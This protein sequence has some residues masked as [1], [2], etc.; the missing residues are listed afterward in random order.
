[1]AEHLLIRA[2]F[3][4]P[5]ERT[6][7]WMMRQ[8][9][10]YLP[11]Y[12]AVREKAD[13]LTM[14]KT[15]ELA[16]EVSLQPLELVGVDAVIFF[17]DI[18]TMLEPMGLEL[19]FGEGEGP[20]FPHPVRTAADVAR[21]RVVDPAE[22]LAFVGEALRL[23]RE[24]IAGRVPLLGFS[25]APYTLATY[26]VEGCTGKNFNHIKRWYYREP[27][28]L[29]PLLEK[30][31]DQVALYL[32]YQIASGAEAVQLFD[33]W[34]GALAPHDYR[35]IA[36][37]Y[38]RRVVEQLHRDGVPVIL[39]INGGGHLLEEMATLGVDVLSLDWRTDM[40]EARARFGATHALQG[41]LDPCALYGTEET[42]RR[43][44]ARILE[45]AGPVGHIFN[46]G[47]GIL[48]DV[49]VENARLFVR[50]VKE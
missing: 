38:T 15:P 27:E 13:F 5:V 49:P 25:G 28:T 48:P 6:P 44:V 31:A 1:M 36:A 22:G 26:A 24:R 32:N 16:A 45:A 42:I 34:A 40:A 43:E 14:C 35:E 10:R 7:V 30:L 20:R 17:S 29:R 11:E 9:G 39:Y 47:H 33:T 19:T 37:P 46:L 23:C 41:N 2:A 50:T 3:R 12:R 18:L 4:Q 21:L 8:A